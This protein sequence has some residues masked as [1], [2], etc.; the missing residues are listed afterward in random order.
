M[1]LPH[2]NLTPFNIVRAVHVAVVA[3]AVATLVL[4]GREL[5]VNFY[6]PYTFS[7][8]VVIPAAPNVSATREDDLSATT[9][10][11][12]A[13]REQPTLDPA[14]IGDA[15]SRPTAQSSTSTPLP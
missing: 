12:E 5:Y 3:A 1:R 11:L 8:A 6:L 4:L 2:L 10:K 14:T 13:I 9:Q 7:D 15:F